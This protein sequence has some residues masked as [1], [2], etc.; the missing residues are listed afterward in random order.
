MQCQNA[1]DAAAIAGARTINGSANSNLTAA[2][3]NAIATATSWQILGKFLGSSEVSV[4]HGAYHYD[5]SI[6]QTFYPQFPPVS[7][8]NYNLAQVTITHKC[9]ARFAE[10]F[11]V[12]STTVTVTATAAHQPRDVAIIWITPGR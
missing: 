5:Y 6:S 3:T 1:A 12:P 2:T 7:P 9:R 8:D 11:G 4:Q 10:I